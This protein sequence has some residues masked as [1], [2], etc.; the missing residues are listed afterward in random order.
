MLRACGYPL[1]M[2]WTLNDSTREVLLEVA[3]ACC[4]SAHRPA[5]H[6]NTRGDACSGSEG[7]RGIQMLSS[8]CATS[9]TMALG[10]TAS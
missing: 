8:L 1:P 5:I 9:V 7:S 6:N 10:L 3:R 4:T 2:T